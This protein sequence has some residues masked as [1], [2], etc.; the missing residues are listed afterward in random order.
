MRI[1]FTL[2][3]FF[4]D[5]VFGAEWVCIQQMRELLR[6]GHRVGLFYAG[7]RSVPEGQ[8]VE[9]GLKGLRCFPVKFFDTK[10]QVL[11]SVKK[12]HVR[13]LFKH[14]V[15]QFAPDAVIYHHLVRLS[16][17]LPTVSYYRRIP[18][19][20]YLHDFYL[21]CPSYSLLRPDHRICSG[22]DPVKCAACLFT[23][24]FRRL[25]SLSHM[26]AIFAMPVLSIRQMM[27]RR[28][29]TTVSSF[30]SPS[31]FLIQK[32]HDHGIFPDPVIVIPNGC[33][34]IDRTKPSR[35][36]D[37]ARLRFGY[38]GGIYEKKG[39]D[40]LV[41]AFAGKLGEQLVIRGFR[42]AAQIQRFRFR[43]P[44]CRARLE[45]FDPA[46]A[47]FYEKVDVVVVPSIWYENQPSVV[48]EAFS[49]GKPVI[50]SEIGAFPEMVKHNVS[51]LLFKTGDAV[52]LKHKIDYLI[53]NP[54]EIQ[55]LAD[56]IPY[57]PTVSENVDKILERLPFINGVSSLRDSFHHPI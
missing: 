53:G 50:C 40:L 24:R 26:A 44:D 7:N 3:N 46:K 5:R 16:L 39:I 33:E 32:L 29:L 48:I 49:Y 45:M 42:N 4:P 30:V 35:R 25:R 43:H 22:G 47:S 8:L 19:L 12:P 13:R 57:W 14:A 36:P 54:M 55:R 6:R 51:G 31:R 21:V 27:I 9:N 15:E 11:L 37:P 1:L 17:D 20:F 34:P 52:D 28:L 18:S 23:N 38:L 10:G 2:H 41:S 56:G